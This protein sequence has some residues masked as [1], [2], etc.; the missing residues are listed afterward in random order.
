MR[1][2]AGSAITDDALRVKLLDLLDSNVSRLLRVLKS[3][4]QQTSSFFFGTFRLRRQYGLAALLFNRRRPCGKGVTSASAQQGLVDHTELE[5][6][7]KPGGTSAIEEYQRGRS[8]SSGRSPPRSRPNSPTANRSS[9]QAVK[10]RAT[11]PAENCLHLFE[12][13]SPIK[14]LIDAGFIILLLPENIVKRK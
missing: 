2:P 7:F 4:R 10:V 1:A 8:R 3:S 13:K 12:H 14:I 6:D 5:V 11:I 9:I